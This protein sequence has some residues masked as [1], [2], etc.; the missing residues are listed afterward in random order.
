MTP[1]FSKA[2]ETPQQ[3]SGYYPYVLILG[4]YP[5]PA[6]LPHITATHYNKLVANKT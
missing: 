4:R 3:N 5:V 1:P 2:P 6:R